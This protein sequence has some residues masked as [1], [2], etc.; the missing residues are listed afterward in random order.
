MG[1]VTGLE[2][3]ARIVE[4]AKRDGK[5]VVLANGHFDLL[6]VGHVR[7]LEGAR[8]AGDVLVVG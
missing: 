7:Y 4:H 1:S 5:R 2:E 8:A 3:T 6:H